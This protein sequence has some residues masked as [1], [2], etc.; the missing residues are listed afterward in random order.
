MSNN[1]ALHGLLWGDWR[2]EVK[3]TKDNALHYILTSIENGHAKIEISCESY[4]ELMKYYSDNKYYEFVNTCTKL[5]TESKENKAMGE[6]KKAAYTTEYDEDEFCVLQRTDMD[7]LMQQI[8]ICYEDYEMLTDVGLGTKAGQIVAKRLWEELHKADRYSIEHGENSYQ[9]TRI[10][11]GTTCS[12]DIDEQTYTKLHTL[13]NCYFI[14]ACDYIWWET[15]EKN[16]HNIELKLEAEGAKSKTDERFAA[17]LE[18]FKELCK[19][20]KERNVSISFYEDSIDI[21]VE[22]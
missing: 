21:R 9:L 15:F 2:V 20:E 16:S 18:T 3:E 17:T 5:W 13:E 10:R 8:D 4:E 22:R 14:G 19:T 1:I 11:N 6:E 7:G 12:M